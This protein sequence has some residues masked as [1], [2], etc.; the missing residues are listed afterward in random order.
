MSKTDSAKLSDEVDALL[1][2]WQCGQ[3]G[4]GACKPYAEALAA[5]S[6]EINQCPP[7]GE[8]GVREL[9]KLLLREFKPLSAEYPANPS[10][11]VALIDER[12][13]IGCTLCIQAC[14]VDAIVGAAQQLHTVVAK[15]CTGCSLCLPPCP[16]DCI[17]M[18][19]VPATSLGDDFTAQREEQVARAA[20]RERFEL[21]TLRLARAQDE[22]AQRLAAKA[23]SV[24][25][26][27]KQERQA[28]IAA[29]M[30]RARAQRQEATV[31]QP[32]VQSG[33]DA[34]TDTHPDSDEASARRSASESR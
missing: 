30:E 1:P 7:G 25:E 9:A 11:A 28:L 24:D 33:T 10:K 8:R 29:A 34:R 18:M 13:C 19:T 15:L 27:D 17:A 23:S 16:V 32:G 22:K 12:I 6:A 26:R 4:F 14:P 3:C 21:R 31:P 2:Q 20:A 5:G